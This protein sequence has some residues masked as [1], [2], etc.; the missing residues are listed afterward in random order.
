MI[1]VGTLTNM[2]RVKMIDNISTII[3]DPLCILT[4]GTKRTARLSELV[5][6]KPEHQ[7]RGPEEVTAANPMRKA[8]KNIVSQCYIGKYQHS[9]YEMRKAMEDG[10]EILIATK[11]AKVVEVTEPSKILSNSDIDALCYKATQLI[12]WWIDGIGRHGISGELFRGMTAE[13]VVRIYNVES[14]YFIK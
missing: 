5:E 6:I 13:D 11:P 2:G 9:R 14:E 7:K 8:L 3:K 10:E 12:K 1:K 4:D